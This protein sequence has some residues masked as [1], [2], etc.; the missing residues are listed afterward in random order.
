MALFAILAPDK[1]SV[2]KVVDLPSDSVFKPGYV[3]PAI[4]P[5]LPAYNPD[6]QAFPT[7]SWPLPVGGVVTGVWSIATLDAQTQA[8]I[9]ETKLATTARNQLQ[10]LITAGT[11]GNLNVAQLTNAVV[12]MARILK[13]LIR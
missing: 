10:T 4:K 5:A 2:Y 3:F 13:Y 11:S 1:Q 6:T 12:G 9:A 7:I 8:D